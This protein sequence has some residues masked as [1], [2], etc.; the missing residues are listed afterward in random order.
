[1]T[2]IRSIIM[3]F[4]DAKILICDDSILARK[5]LSTMISSLVECTIF[6][7]ANGQECIDMYQQHLPDIVFLDIV[8]PI[9][10][11][12]SA[13]AEIMEKHPDADIVIVSS[14]GTQAQLRQAIQ[15]GAKD[16]IQKPLNTLQIESILKTRFERR[17]K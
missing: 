12:H 9:K 16:F 6:E 5:Q 1:M 11:G 7:A 14:V 17:M 13:I 3:N 8:M 2:G 15:L 10:D 4:E